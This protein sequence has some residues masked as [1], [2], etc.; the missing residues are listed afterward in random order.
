MHKKMENK[1]YIRAVGL[2]AYLFQMCTF[3]DQ[4]EKNMDNEVETGLT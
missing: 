4:M 2:G 1:M 3:I